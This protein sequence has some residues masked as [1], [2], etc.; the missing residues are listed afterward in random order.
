ML[1]LGVGCERGTEGAELQ[2]LVVSTISEH[3]LAAAA[4]A[5]VVSLDLKAAEPAIHSLAT[6][7]GVPAR[8]FPAAQLEAERARLANPSSEV[9]AVTG[10]HGVAEGAALAAAGVD[11]ELVVAKTKSARA[12][13]ALARAPMPLDPD[14]IGRAQGRLALVGLG[15]GDAGWRTPEARALLD[16]AEDWVGYGGYLRLLEGSIPGRRRCAT[17]SRWARKKRGPA[18]PSIWPR[19]D[20]ASP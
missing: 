8:F 9:F 15:P 1:A 2:D 13:C 4:I 7:L 18:A 10:C 12:T 19:R 5:C 11:G 3:G 6:H 17:L 20:A 16:D 14:R